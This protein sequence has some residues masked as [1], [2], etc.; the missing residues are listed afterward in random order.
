MEKKWDLLLIFWQHRKTK[1]FLRMK[2]LMVLLLVGGMHLSATTFSQTKVS[3]KMTDVTVQEVFS[4]LERITNYTFL[5]KLD[6]VGK[7][8]K[9]NVDVTDREFDELLKDLLSP[10]GLAFTIDDQVVVITPVKMEDNKKK[11]ITIKGRVFTKDSTGVPGATVILKGTSTGVITNIAGEFTITIPYTESPVLKFSFLGMKTREVKYVGQKEMLVLMEED[12]KAMDEVV[13]TGYQRIRKSD[14][15][16]STN[17]VKREDLFFD[18]TNS[19]E[20]MLQG[21]L[22]GM[23]V[24]NTSGLVGKRQ[25]VRVRGTS[26]LLG[27]QEPVWVVDGIIQEDPI[28]FKSR[29]LDAYGSISQDNFDMVK[30]F[31]G[32]AIAWLSPNDIEDITVLKDA[33]ATVMY[34]VKAANGVILIKTKR[35][36]AGRMSVNY[37]GS[38]A[39][40]PRLTYEKMNLMNSKERVEVSREVYA[41]GLTANQRPLESIGYE[42]LLGRY[43]AKEIS[44]DEFDREVKKLETTNT[45]WFGLLFRNSVS[46]NHSLSV[47][48]GTDK[49]SYYGSVNATENKGT[50]IGNE[51]TSYS[52]SLNFSA[53]F[54]EKIDLTFGVNASTAETQGYY[55]VDPFGY[56]S[57]TSRVIPCFAEDGKKYFYKDVNGYM[58]NILHELSM[59]GNKNTTRSMGASVN[60]RWDILKG[61]QFESSFGLNTSNVVG[62]S[63]ADE[64][65]QYI[66]KLRRY[67]FG[68]Q[69]PADRLYQESQL[70][71]G[72]ELNTTENRN[73]NY[74]WRNVLSYNYVLA[75]KHRFSLMIGQE[76]RSNKYD[77]VSSTIYGYYPGRGKSVTMPPI[78]VL[79][80][81][82]D[83]YVANELLKSFNTVVTD[84]K[85]NYL[86]FFGSFSYG[87]NERYV[88]TASLRSDASNRFG[89]DTRNR[90]LPVW[91]VGAR[92]NVHYEPWMQNQ[93]VISDLNFRISYGWQGNVAENYGPDLIARVGSGATTIDQNRTGEYM[94]FIKSLPYGNLRWEKTKTINMGTDFGLFENKVTWTVEYYYK[95]TEDMIVEKQVPYAYGVASM[96]INGGNMSNQGLEISAGFTP[97]RTKNF[98]WNVSVNTS[99]NFNKVKSDLNEYKN[100]QAAVSGN[101]NKNGYAVS[102]FWAFDFKGLNP[103]TGAAEFN[104]LSAE[105]NP[106]V[107]SDATTFMK[108]MGTLEPDFQG[109]VS[110][111]WRYKSLSLSTS[112][113]LQIGGKKF[114]YHVFDEDMVTSTPSAYVNL[115][116][117]MVKRW[118]KSGD[119]LKTDVPALLSSSSTSVTL[120]NG[121]T[122]YSPRLY[123]YSDVR[124]VD[125][126]FLRCNSL[127]LNYTL[128]EK[129]IKRMCLK[130]LALSASMSNP[131]KIVSKGF[132]GIDP[133]VATGAQP[134]SRTY[135]FGINVSL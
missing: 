111:S 120:P 105:E 46:M 75:E 126:S 23:L 55:Q 39:I 49:I 87:F 95:K 99:K 24:M 102:S 48:G 130:N 76:C 98:V 72:G 8:G 41:R 122:D 27:N 84:R 82:G 10:L 66:T 70:P 11:E 114:L 44:Y 20:Q 81:G 89:Q 63:F 103:E 59:T 129:W 94:M 115:P 88:L 62:E 53:K 37:S 73:F 91:S 45:D 33:S 42:G 1:F 18:G 110:M 34:G 43:L 64:Q 118:K 31:V 79:N 131:F 3:L 57:K 90:F 56:A 12:V 28:P 14:M 15:V 38:V 50:S 54:G 85:S 93:R 21:K 83:D 9:V 128:P 80:P 117:E 5:Y 97:V 78:T 113:N 22:P 29:E 134:L 125:A 58:Y 77:G 47:S 30:D 100:W 67:E 52:A 69:R 92:W 65:S 96:P 123:N 36:K 17:T 133:E 35:G 7:C 19:I 112:F 107:L 101:L 26:T 61:L 13:V 71:N 40:T 116:K 135:S 127:S 2:I 124:V 104:M 68:S 74:T 119:E 108:Y 109:G 4:S 132:R 106:D 51:S 86:G 121:V 6:L 60:F 25:K 32:N 16:G